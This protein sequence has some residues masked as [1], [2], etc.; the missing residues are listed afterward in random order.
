ML[1]LNEFKKIKS[2]IEK[3]EAEIKKIDKLGYYAQ[4][5]YITVLEGVLEKD[6]LAIEFLKIYPYLD[7]EGRINMAKIIL[8]EKE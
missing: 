4:I 8:N 1:K 6:P 2:A 3:C 5:V 7:D